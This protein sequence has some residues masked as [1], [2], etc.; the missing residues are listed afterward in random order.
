MKSINIKIYLFKI[1]LDGKKAIDR[2]N[3]NFHEDEIFSLL[4][5]NRAGKTTIISILAEIYD[6]VQW[7]SHSL[8]HT[9]VKLLRQSNPIFTFS[10]IKVWKDDESK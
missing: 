5:Y 8:F 6:S 10:L 7:K 2:I 4:V 3:L 9:P 1:F